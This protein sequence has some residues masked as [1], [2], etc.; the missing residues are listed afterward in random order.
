MSADEV[1][2]EREL[3]RQQLEQIYRLMEQNGDKFGVSSMEEIQQQMKL[4]A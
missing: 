3:Q 2:A 4:Y 1:Q